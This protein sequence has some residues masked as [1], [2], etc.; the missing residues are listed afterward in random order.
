MKQ[1]IEAFPANI[2]EALEI[3]QNSSI[4]GDY[5]NVSNILICGMG[6]SGIGGSLVQ[7]WLADELKVPVSIAKDYSIPNFVNEN[8]LVIGSSYSGNT[9]ETLSAIEEAQ[10]KGAKIIG[11][12]SGGKMEALCESNGYDFIKVPGGNPPRT[13]LAY[14]LVQLLHIFATIGMS[15]A[16]RL[17]EMAA[18]RDLIVADSETIHMKAKGLAEHLHQKV[19]IMYGTTAY[20]PVLVRARQQFNE[21]SKYL[22][23]TNPIPEMNHNELVGWGGGDRRFAPVFF[24][25][26]GNHPR[27]DKRIEITRE[28]IA[29]KTAVFDIHAKGDSQIEQSLYLINIVDWASF[30][31][32]AL[33]DIDTIDIAVIDY[34]KGTLAKF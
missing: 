24:K 6:G 26:Q 4:S 13:A 10:K 17:N 14:S 25:T 8:T 12:T 9:E 20:D 7:T 15:S 2:T 5:G 31:L 19:G 30:Y 34:L 29:E 28:K 16:D 11:I 21:N 23:W 32:A 22:N 33:D 1:L 27:N 3:A 18:G